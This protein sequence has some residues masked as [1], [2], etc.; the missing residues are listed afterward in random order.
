[1]EKISGEGFVLRPFR[2]A[3]AEQFVTAVLESAV[4][5]DASMPWWKA[6]YSEKD[7]L[8]FFDSCAQAIESGSA[9]DAGIFQ[10]DGVSLI[11]GVAINRIDP[12]YKIGNV[13]YWVRE[14][15]QNHG[16]CTLAASAI[17]DF[18]FETLCLVRL[19]IVILEGN[20]ASRRVAE[21]VGGKLECI[22]ENRIIHKGQAMPAAV[23]S[24]VSK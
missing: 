1:M 19:E 5:L 12:D 8:E 10:P 18:G 4:T 14:S 17:A 16:I 22:A 24:L 11:G 7:A 20:A 13:G 6:D 9:Y 2:S 21:K 15:M 23:Y 3:D